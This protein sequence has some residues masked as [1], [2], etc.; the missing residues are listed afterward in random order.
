MFPPI[1]YTTLWKF[2]RHAGNFALLFSKDHVR[3]YYQTSEVTNTGISYNSVSQANR[4]IARGFR[5]RA[6]CRKA[7]LEVSIG[8]NSVENPCIAKVGS[9]KHLI[10]LGKY[11]VKCDAFHSLSRFIVGMPST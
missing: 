11:N 4:L 1:G 7:E 3:A 2:T 9:S 6:Y 5:Y 8:Q 10:I